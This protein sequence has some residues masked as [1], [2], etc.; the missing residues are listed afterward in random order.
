MLLQRAN[1]PFKQEN[2][3]EKTIYIYI[4]ETLDRMQNGVLLTDLALLL[5]QPVYM[6][7]STWL[8]Q[9][10]LQQILLK[11]WELSCRVISYIL[12]NLKKR[13]NSGIPL[14]LLD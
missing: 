8:R 11:R 14:Y 4:Y 10:G 12:I 7:Y 9:P 13:Q 1:R 6:I 2:S 5:W 3:S